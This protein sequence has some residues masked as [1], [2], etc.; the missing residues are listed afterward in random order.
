MTG[1]ATLIRLIVRRDRVRLPVW[2]LG[3]AVLVWSSAVAVEGLYPS[4]ADL[5]EAA[6]P[7]YDNAAV[8]ALQGPTYA[9][10]TLGGQIVF[11]LGA[12]GHIVMALMGMFLVGRHTR[13]DEEEG[14]T[15]LLRATVVGRDAPVTA[16][17]VVAAAAFA[18]LGLLIALSVLSTGVAVSGSFLYGAAMAGFGLLFACV[19]AVT[20]QISS[21]NRAALG[22]AGAVLGASYLIRAI[23]DIGSGTLSWLSPMGWAQRA[24]PFAGDDWW[25]LGLLAAGCIAL[26]GATFVLLDRRD[27]GS[28]LVSPRPGP[29]RAAPA[30]TTPVGLAV[31]LQR[32]A[33]AGWLAGLVLAGVAYGSVGNDVADLVGDSQSIEDIIARAGGDLTDSFF[34]S[35]LLTLA[36]LG[37]GYAI[38]SA[39]RLR[40][41]EAGG[42]LE[43]LLATAV[44][45]R[46]WAASHTALA[47]VGSAVVML[48]VGLAI[49]ITF[50]VVA[51]D[52]GQVARLTG[53]ALAFVPALWV[54]VGVAVAL[55]G[56][57]PRAV[58]AA[59]GALVLCLVIGLFGEVFDLPTWVRDVSPFQHVPRMP[60]EGFSPVPAVVLTS[61]AAALLVVGFVGF[62]RRDAGT[63]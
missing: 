9:I 35:S 39:L 40:S 54:L 59:W 43:P 38:S 62:R 2:I 17:L 28:G 8:I 47:L 50:A 10:D 45:R 24:R 56:L 15:E 14:R 21:H 11:Q 6:A 27:L 34:Q 48:A 58:G 12:F 22:M 16:A 18:L 49:G 23:G 7:L 31:R 51:R 42:R 52:G 32:P 53:A 46:R 13:G 4:Q 60:V 19:T 25:T 1:T 55:F 20:V 33:L 3:V 30:L 29:A 44:S 36:L 63:A 37:G 5:D 26:V 41:E 57:A 61:V